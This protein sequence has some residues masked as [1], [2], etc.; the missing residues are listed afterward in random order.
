M[1]TVPGSANLARRVAR[2][3]PVEAA[4]VGWSGKAAVGTRCSPGSGEVKGQNDT[5][6]WYGDGSQPERRDRGKVEKP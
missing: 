6:K 3:Q 5:Y 4:A 2:G 1:S